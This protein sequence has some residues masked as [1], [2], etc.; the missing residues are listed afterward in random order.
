MGR[1]TR[2]RADAG[3]GLPVVLAGAF[4]QNLSMP[5]L[6]IQ[7]NQAV[8]PEDQGPLLD[9]FTA[10]VAEELGKP[11]QFVQVVLQTG[12]PMAFGGSTA[13]AAL[14]ELASLGLPAEAPKRLTA[15][16]CRLLNERLQVAPE[17][18]FLVF[19]DHPRTHWGW[20]G[21]TFG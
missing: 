9:V 4:P 11:V 17:R 7:T 3:P 8:A 19:D 13:P 15:R 5:L 18:I 10:T 6:R 20:N 2:R 16:F 12:L 1:E 21:S 14:V